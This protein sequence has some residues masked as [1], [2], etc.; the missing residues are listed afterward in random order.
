M[1]EVVRATEVMYYRR[2]KEFGGLNANEIGL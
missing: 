2:R 1:A